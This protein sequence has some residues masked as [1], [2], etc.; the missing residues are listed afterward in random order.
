[1]DWKTPK[2]TSKPK[3]S[4]SDGRDSMVISPVGDRLRLSKYMRFGLTSPEKDEKMFSYI[5]K[6]CEEFDPTW[7]IK[8]YSVHVGLRPM[9]VYSVPKI[10][11][12]KY[13]NLYS[14]VGHGMLGWTLAHVT[15]KK[16]ADTVS[17]QAA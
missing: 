9:R 6:Q 13:K 16:C 5:I 15:G 12:T 10:D 2:G 14:N 11:R 3:L 1:M 4:I 8:D 17:E 7:Q